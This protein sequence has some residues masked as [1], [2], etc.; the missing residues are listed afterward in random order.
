LTTTS[1]AD[2]STSDDS[3]Q[4]QAL[5]NETLASIFKFLMVDQQLK[6]LAAAAQISKTIYDL[7]IP[8]LYQKIRFTANNQERLLYGGISSAD[9]FD[10]GMSEAFCNTDDQLS[11]VDQFSSAGKI[12]P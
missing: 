3:S 11:K 1:K 5:P 8:L 9:L 12:S 4:D 10:H 2:I 7:V 6:T